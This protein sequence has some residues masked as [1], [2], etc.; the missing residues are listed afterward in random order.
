MRPG[1]WYHSPFFFPRSPAA[2]EL[3]ASVSG[4]RRVASR[5]T[6]NT[7]QRQPDARAAT[8]YLSGRTCREKRPHPPFP[9]PCW[10]F[11]PRCCFSDVPV[12]FRSADSASAGRTARTAHD[13]STALVGRWN[14]GSTAANGI[15]SQSVGISARST[16]PDVPL[17]ARARVDEGKRFTSRVRSPT[18]RRSRTQCDVGSMLN[19][20]LPSVPAGPRVL[21]LLKRLFDVRNGL[22][23]SHAAAVGT[24][25]IEQWREIRPVTPVCLYCCGSGRLGTCAAALRKPPA[26]PGLFRSRSCAGLLTCERLDR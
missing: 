9:P 24:V 20:G 11:S 23:L 4:Y 5:A 18:S 3:T 12:L 6:K 2:A 8:D 21:T 19:F 13:C 17:R 26:D 7:S 14:A 10:P 15:C 25:R 1:H 16:S 22:I